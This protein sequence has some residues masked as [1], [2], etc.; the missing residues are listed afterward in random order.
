VRLLTAVCLLAVLPTLASADEPVAAQEGATP[1]GETE[2]VDQTRLDVERLPPEAIELDRD[3][4][5][6]GFYFDASLSGRGFIGGAGRVLRGGPA[7]SVAMGYELARWL[8]LYAGFDGSLH[9]TDAPAPPAASVVEVIGAVVG[10]RFQINASARAAFFLGG[11]F[12]LVWVTSD[13]LRPYGYRDFEGTGISYGGDLG[14]DW[15]F[16]TRHHSFGIKTGADVM[17]SLRAPQGDLAIAVHGEL[18]LRYVF[19]N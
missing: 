13:A 19:G 3:M 5:A 18:Y 7:L 12:G 2:E 15:H 6:H 17:P 11:R 14:F 4:Y 16:R 9:P 8:Y 10:V 1:G